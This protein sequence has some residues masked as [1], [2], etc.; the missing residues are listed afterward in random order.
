MTTEVEQLAAQLS[1]TFARR[2]GADVRPWLFPSLLQLLAR[3]EA[4]TTT[5][6]AAASGKSVEE[7]DQAL[8]ALPDAEF[9]DQGRVVGYGITLRPTPH[10][11]EV[12]GQQL[13]TWCALDTLIFPAVLGRPAR[14]ESPCHSTGAP[15]RVTVAPTGVTSVEPS[16]SVVSIVTPED[17]SRLRSAFCNEVHF[18]SSPAAAREWLERHPGA[19]VLPVSEAFELGRRLNQE[20]GAGAGPVECC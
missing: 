7:V 1:D 8:S 13:Y 9:D 16:T 20:L 11:F 6:V 2:E 12:D 5:D 15:V 4:V 19:T 18:F 14:I 10:R 3:G 17:L